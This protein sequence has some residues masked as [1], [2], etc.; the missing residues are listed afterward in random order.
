MG[1]KSSKLGEEWNLVLQ[2]RNKGLYF[3][4]FF[5]FHQKKKS[6]YF[7]NVS[8]YALNLS[9]QGLFSPINPLLCFATS[10]GVKTLQLTEGRRLAALACRQPT[11]HSVALSEPRCLDSD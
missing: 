11:D 9:P 7:V 6:F 5:H 3:C 4:T 10:N 2:R 8:L 1:Q